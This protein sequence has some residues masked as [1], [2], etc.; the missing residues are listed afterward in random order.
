ML[1]R[2]KL[3][4]DIHLWVRCASWG[5]LIGGA[6][7]FYKISG[8]FPPMAWRLLASTVQQ[9]AYLWSLRG[10]AIVLPLMIVGIQSLACLIVWGLIIWG[11]GAVLWHWW[12]NE[13][14]RRAFARSVHEALEQREQQKMTQYKPQFRTPS[15]DNLPPFPSVMGS[16]QTNQAS[17]TAQ[18]N[19]IGQARQGI[20][21]SPIKQPVQTVELD[22]MDTEQKEQTE[23]TTAASLQWKRKLQLRLEIGSG[24]DAGCRCWPTVAASACSAGCGLR[25]SAPGGCFW[26]AISS[27]GKTAL[28]ASGSTCAT[29][30]PP[31]P[32]TT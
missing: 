26:P 18:S 7:L 24:W 23:Q 8:G 22:Q 13:R 6:G 3:T 28:P 4:Y 12:Q 5:M 10:P 16:G 15:F 27:R 17:Q 19:Q 30:W 1:E 14:E 9:L 20:Q 25:R 21:V 11:W 29:A 2:F 31:A 32:P